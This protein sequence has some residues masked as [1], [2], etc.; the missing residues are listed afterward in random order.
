MLSLQLFS[1]SVIFHFPISLP[2][3]VLC[4]ITTITAKTV[5]IKD[6]NRRE[7]TKEGWRREQG[8]DGVGERR[9]TSREPYWV[10]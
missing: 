3:A 6:D 10:G 2:L 4:L 9:I 5:K 8:G 7:N 1:F